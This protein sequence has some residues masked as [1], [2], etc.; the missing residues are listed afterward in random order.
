MRIPHRDDE[1]TSV[2]GIDTTSMR[3]LPDYDAPPVIETVLGVEFS[4]LEKWEIPHFGLFWSRVQARFPRFEVNPPLGSNVESA[5]LEFKQPTP[6]RVELMSKPQVRCWFLNE[7]NTELIQVQHD[8]FVH[9]WRKV[10][11]SEIYPHYDTYIRSA[12]ERNWKQFCEFLDT[13]QIGAPDVRQCEITY[14]NHIDRGKGWDSFA[15]LSEV[16]PCWSGSTSGHFLPPPETV[17][18]NVSYVMPE[19]RGRLR[20]ALVHAFRATDAKETLQ[21]TLTARG[22]PCSAETS[23]ILQWLDLGREWV[24]QG[25]TDFTSKKMHQRW[26]RKI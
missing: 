10:A 15:E 19:N 3:A 22:K 14:V 13:E 4:P 7:S 23:E 2:N 11:G 18:F 6:P 5:Q 20:V 8:R 16:F 1:A 26:R 25:F 17:L 21:L 12:F 9:N 24:V